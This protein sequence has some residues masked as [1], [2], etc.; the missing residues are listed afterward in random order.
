MSHT[1]SYI[2]NQ[3]TKQPNSAARS[4]LK[5]NP[6]LLR[7]ILRGIEKESLR[8]DQRGK[9]VQTPHPKALGAALTHPSITTDYSEALLEFIT[10]P[11]SSVSTLL[12]QLDD[13]HRY[14]YRHIGSE[15]LWTSSMPCALSNDADI[16]VAQ[17]GSSNVGRMKT[18]YRLGLGHRYGRSMQTIAGIHYN[19]SLPDAL[20]Q[21]L[22]QADNSPLSLTDYKTERYFALI[23]NFRRHY[24]LLIYL[25]GA[26]PAVCRSFIKGREHHLVPFEGDDHTLHSPYATSLRMGDLGYQSSAQG[27]L[28][29]CYNNLD[30]YLKT[31]C[32][33]IT[34]AHPDYQNIGVRNGHNSDGDGNSYRQLNGNLLQIENEFYSAIRP[35]RTAHSGETALGALHRGGVEYIEV[36]CIDLNPFEPL[37]INAEQIQFIDSF[38]LHCLL[39][40]SPESDAEEHSRIQENQ[41]RVVYRGREPQ[42]MLQTASGECSLQECA[43][44]LLS[45]IA[46]AADLLDHADIDD[47]DNAKPHTAACTQQY[48]KLSNPELMPSAQLLQKM[49]DNKQTFFRLSMTQA[50]N[51]QNHFLQKSPATDANIEQQFKALAE[52]SWRDQTAIEQ[53]D[54]IDFETYLNNFYQQYQHCSDNNAP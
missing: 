54:D 22:H 43:T 28:V 12:Q 21:A 17:Y 9:L 25:F 37:G 1:S 19:F 50:L 48:A 2:L 35:K 8:V 38:L 52:K 29:V 33:A 10:Q 20:W 11:H 26:A 16:P 5:K 24:W 30:N 32:S 4:L 36:R 34:R 14:T 39:T 3:T 40:D 51:H 42:L 44:T 27:E 47:A 7:G 41:S 49:R 53:A 13:T 23:R 31:L 15:I 18:V 46:S 6:Q 45:S